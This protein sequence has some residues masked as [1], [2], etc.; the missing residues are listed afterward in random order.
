[1]T[2]IK[3]VGNEDQ[4]G[5]EMRH[6]WWNTKVSVHQRER[7]LRFDTLLKRDH[8]DNEVKW[9]NNS[10]PHRSKTESNL[11]QQKDALI[12]GSLGGKQQT[13]QRTNEQFCATLK[14]KK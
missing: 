7:T 8:V 5:R 12:Q 9:S 13:E 1:M 10:L 4:G 2:I 3:H 11:H 6:R 14:Q